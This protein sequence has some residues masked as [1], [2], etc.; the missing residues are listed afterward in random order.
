MLAKGQL[1]NF[2]FRAKE[3]GV[4]H[5]S[6]PSSCGADNEWNEDFATV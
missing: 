6:T 3:K 2:G 5:I 4:K 1:V